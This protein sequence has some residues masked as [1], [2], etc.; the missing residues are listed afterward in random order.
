MT[1]ERASTKTT[2]K[3]GCLAGLLG[4]F[5]RPQPQ[6]E[7]AVLPYRLRRDL[8]SP[9][10]LTFFHALQPLL[11]RRYCLFTKVR[12]A[13]VV[14]VSQRDHYYTHFNRI[15]AKHLDF[16][17]CAADSLAP[18]VALELDDSSH[19]RPDRQARDQFVDQV[20]AAAGLPLLHLPVKP[21]Y[22]AD[23]LIAHLAPH[24]APTIKPSA[25][26]PAPTPAPIPD[27]P[28]CPTCGIPMVLRTVAKGEHQGKQFYGCRNFP[29]CRQMKPAP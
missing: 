11:D 9:A 15:S 28:V 27:A 26:A 13:D 20:C 24:L 1:T 18:V 21:R 8:L 29:T 17:I 3:R 25:P 7:A 2:A 6:E 23:E 16:L 5:S 14:A 4:L 19:Q 22:A 10:E 12:L